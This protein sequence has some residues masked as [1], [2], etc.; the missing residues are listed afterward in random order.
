[1]NLKHISDNCE[2]LVQ[3]S[4]GHIHTTKSRLHSVQLHLLMITQIAS[5]LHFIQRLIIIIPSRYQFPTAFFI[6]TSF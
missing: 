5:S 3:F 1:M 2:C 4:N 6:T